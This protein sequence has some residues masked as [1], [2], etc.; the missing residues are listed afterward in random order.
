LD[1]EGVVDGA[2]MAIGMMKLIAPVDRERLTNDLLNTAVTAA[3][4]IDWCEGPAKQNRRT[5]PYIC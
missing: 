2:E 4:S 1:G 5:P 3:L